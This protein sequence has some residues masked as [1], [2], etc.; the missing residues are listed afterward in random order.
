M[1]H[2]TPLPRRGPVGSWGSLYEP[3]TFCSVRPSSRQ[4]QRRT[5][6]RLYRTDNSYDDRKRQSERARY[7]RFALG[8]QSKT[9]YGWPDFHGQHPLDLGDFFIPPGK[10]R[11][12]RLL[13]DPPNVPPPPAAVLDVHAS[14]TGFDFSRSASFG[15]PGEAFITLFGDQS[16]H[17][18]KCCAPLDS[19]S[20]VSMYKPIALRSSR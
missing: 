9:W 1:R 11:P 17:R 20:C 12:P 14:A 4:S 18:E 13:L 2:S 8:C 10:P 16:P 3:R 6:R 5:N 7:R 19:R 15:Y